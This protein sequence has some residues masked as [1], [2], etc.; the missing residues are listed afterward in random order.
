MHSRRVRDEIV[1]VDIGF[2]LIIIDSVPAV[3]N[4]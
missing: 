2:L 3:Q 4:H 1:Q